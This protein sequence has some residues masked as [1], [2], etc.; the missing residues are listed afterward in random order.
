MDKEPKKNDE[1]FIKKTKV[2]SSDSEYSFLQGKTDILSEAELDDIV[3]E[4]LGQE[5]S[6]EDME[7]PEFTEITEESSE[8]VTIEEEITEEVTES[9]T[10][11][12]TVISRKVA[13]KKPVVNNEILEKEVVNVVKKLGGEVSEREVNNLL[14]VNPSLKS[15]LVSGNMEIS[16]RKNQSIEEKKELINKL[17]EISASEDVS[18]ANATVVL[19]WLKNRN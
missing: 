1:K 2:G 17:E 14:K 9:K 11:K 6:A 16:A 10:G 15:Q 7:D 4:E 19:K 12:I 8:E 13:I 3:K 18:K 5:I